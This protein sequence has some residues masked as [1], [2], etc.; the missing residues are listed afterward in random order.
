[1]PNHIKLKRQLHLILLKI[2]CYIFALFLKQVTFL[3][4]RFQGSWGHWMRASLKT[5]AW[6]TMKQAAWKKK[7]LVTCRRQK[8]PYIFNVLCHQFGIS[9]RQKWHNPRA[10]WTGNT[11]YPVYTLCESPFF[12]V[13]EI[14]WLSAE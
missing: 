6:E 2:W 7:V 12:V 3:R 11:F 4:R 14:W 1:M 13:A 9:G 10:L 8:R 5:P